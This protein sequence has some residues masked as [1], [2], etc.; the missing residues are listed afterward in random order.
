MALEWIADVMFRRPMPGVERYLKSR[1]REPG[2][3]GNSSD[4]YMLEEKIASLSTLSTP[5]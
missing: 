4:I 5:P 3:D 2:H 1:T